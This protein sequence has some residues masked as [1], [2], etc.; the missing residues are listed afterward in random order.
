MCHTLLGY[1]LPPIVEQEMFGQKN[2]AHTR[3][4]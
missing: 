1:I 3:D 4:P 2:S